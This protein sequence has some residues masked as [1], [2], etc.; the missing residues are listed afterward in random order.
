MREHEVIVVR[1]FSLDPYNLIK[2]TA[3]SVKSFGPDFWK[4]RQNEYDDQYD[5]LCLNNYLETIT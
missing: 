2:N 1:D 3:T 4:N 5:T